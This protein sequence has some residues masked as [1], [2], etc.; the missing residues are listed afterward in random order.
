MLE[1]VLEQ[2]IYISTEIYFSIQCYKTFRIVQNAHPLNYSQ[3][4]NLSTLDAY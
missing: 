1:I 3:F 4:R 2:S